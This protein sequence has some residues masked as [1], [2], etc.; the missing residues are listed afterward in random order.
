MIVLQILTTNPSHPTIRL[1]NDKLHNYITFKTNSNDETNKM[2]L[3]NI[4]LESSQNS[5]HGEFYVWLELCTLGAANSVTFLDSLKRRTIDNQCISTK[6]RNNKKIDF[7]KFEQFYIWLKGSDGM[8]WAR[9][10]Y[11][12]LV[13]KKSSFLNCSEEKT[14]CSLLCF[15][16]SICLLYICKF[17]DWWMNERVRVLCIFYS[18][19]TLL[20]VFLGEQKRTLLKPFL[21]YVG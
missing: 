7:E 16:S 14:I 9:V 11:I 5:S 4:I 15:C 3:S 12:E 19:I 6:T 13:S 21:V 2:P 8:L 18:V 20:S 17:V 1:Q 10:D